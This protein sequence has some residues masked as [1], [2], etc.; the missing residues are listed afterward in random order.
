[1]ALSVSKEIFEEKFIKD[2]QPYYKIYEGFRASGKRVRF[3][4]DVTDVDTSMNEISEVFDWFPEG[5][6]LTIVTGSSANAKNTDAITVQWGNGGKAGSTVGSSQGQQPGFGS[7][8]FPMLQWMQQQQNAANAQMLA[9]IEKQGT[10]NVELMRLQMEKQILEE[11]NDALAN[12]GPEN[13]LIGALANTVP[14]IV[15]AIAAHNGYG[16]ISGTLGVKSAV[17]PA[18]AK[19]EKKVLSTTA[20]PAAPTVQVDA[21]RV[22]SE[23]VELQKL[24]GDQPIH[25]LMAKLREKLEDDAMR[26]F[27]LQQL[28]K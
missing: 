21:I 16:G 9:L 11:E 18:A 22:I 25:E 13:P 12:A 6:T 24:V 23:A 17:E 15:Q 19:T 10:T 27:L 26:A 7:N 2:G 4:K 28:N 5:A 14:V 1:M 3:A 20:A 8:M